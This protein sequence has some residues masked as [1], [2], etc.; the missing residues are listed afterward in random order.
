MMKQVFSF[1]RVI[2]FLSCP[3]LCYSLVAGVL[4]A[5]A[6][7]AQ[8]EDTKGPYT[9][10]VMSLVVAPP[11][12][13][14]LLTVF[15]GTRMDGLFRSTDRGRSWRQVGFPNRSL[16]ALLFIAG[17]G[18]A[19]RTLLAAPF[20]GYILYRST[21]N[22]ST[23]MPLNANSPVQ[24]YFTELAA[25]N[26]GPAGSGN[27][28]FAAT[29][30]AI[31]GF[32]RS[33]DEGVT[34]I[35]AGTGLNGRWVQSI[36]P[37]T[38]AVGSDRAIFAG[39]DWGLYRSTNNGDNW[40]LLPGPLMY[41][42]ITDLVMIPDSAGRSPAILAATDGRGIFRSSDNGNTWSDINGNIPTYYSRV[43][44][45]S[46]PD[47]GM[48]GPVIF[49]A[50]FDGV[51][52]STDRGD[53]WTKS[54][55]SAAD[56][57]S[58]AFSPPDS[59]GPGLVFCGTWQGVYRSD[60]NGSS[61]SAGNSGLLLLPTYSLCVTPPDAGGEQVLLAGTNGNGVFIHNRYSRYY[62]DA[63]N[64]GMRESDVLD[65]V[66]Q[67]KDSSG[68]IQLFAGTRHN[69]VFRSTASTLVWSPAGAGLPQA[70]IRALA[71]LPADS[72]GSGVRLFAGTS[73]DGV[74]V[75]TDGAGS[76]TPANA[77]LANGDVRAFAIR[78][79]S[80]TGSGRLFAG[81]RGGVFLSDDGGGN[82]IAANTGLTDKVINALHFNP[83]YGPGS[84]VLFAGTAA[85]GIFRSTNGGDSWI[86]TNAGMGDRDIRAFADSGR[87]VFAG[88][89]RGLVFLSTD[90]GDS[91]N[92]VS[93]GLEGNAL[94]DLAIKGTT[95]NAATESG[96][97]S[98]PLNQM[99]VSVERDATPPRRP[100]LLKSHP[101]PFRDR[102]NVSFTLPSAGHVRLR[103]FD[104]LGRE[105][106]ALI[107][108][109]RASGRHEVPFDASHMRA[110]TYF[111]RL[112]ADGKISIGKVTILK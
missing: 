95:I 8:W 46:P 27:Y 109:D 67:P 43:L 9:G 77:G 1:I 28:L 87:N 112:E 91:W 57:T 45:F 75:S 94:Y 59:S 79:A 93:S 26:W 4:F 89:A 42:D 54:G 10:N 58:F 38:T 64:D 22:G 96:V 51:Y 47:W 70:E 83:G 81:T 85:G 2:S 103:V 6:L 50:T 12:S 7:H 73:G 100:A 110:G 90:G 23:W 15:A 82:W 41:G 40:T 17:G 106:A 71:L 84:G 68:T 101:N 21:D 11:D 29:D 3:P 92:S 88:T 78:P 86:G 24:G 48:G 32:W 102:T 61:W 35:K 34:W 63:A 98:R 76:W 39:T 52:R 72:T 37:D 49:A 80:S 33:S 25:A 111:L 20:A 44:G 56:P 5:N 65:L 55:L 105:A 16:S 104:A 108:E 19:R 14:T 97:W 31:G 69:G 36:L 62:W 13:T 107:D 18:A 53:T 60:D 66:A 99:I 74:Y 30:G